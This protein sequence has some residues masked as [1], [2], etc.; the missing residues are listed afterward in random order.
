MGANDPYVRLYD[1]RM[2]KITSSVKFVFFSSNLSSCLNAYF[3]NTTQVSSA[4]PSIRQSSLLTN[5]QSEEIRSAI[6]FGCVQYFAPGKLHNL[7]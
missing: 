7:S 4:I 1:R 5:S 2:I 3:N 6:P